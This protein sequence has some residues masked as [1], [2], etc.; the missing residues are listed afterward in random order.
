[1]EN[2]LAFPDPANQSQFKAGS[3]KKK[4]LLSMATP[5]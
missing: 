1:M 4:I 3:N 5:I 2:S